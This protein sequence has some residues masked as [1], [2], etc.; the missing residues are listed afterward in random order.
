MTASFTV[1]MVGQMMQSEFLAG[2]FVKMVDL[3]CTTPEERTSTMSTFPQPEVQQ[4][5]L[6]P[7]YF[8]VRGIWALSVH[9]SGV[10]PLKPLLPFE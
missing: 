10:S 3:P 6:E 4:L 5:Q 9:M 7:P 1:S 8:M 2:S